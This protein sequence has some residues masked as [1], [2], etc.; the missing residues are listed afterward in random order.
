MIKGKVLTNSN[1]SADQ[2]RSGIG[3][4]NENSLHAEIIQSITQD[5]DQLEAEV[6]G[7]LIDIFRPGRLI[8]VQTKNIGSLSRK[9][10]ILAEHSPVEIV[11]PI[12]KTKII[13]KIDRDGS[14][15]G[16]RKSPKQG[17]LVDVFYELVRA[18]DII[19]HPDV[20]LTILLVE[21]K[22]IWK[23]DGLGSWRRKGWSIHGRQLIKILSKHTFYNPPDLLNLL[24][25]SL[26]QSFSNLQV[27]HSLGISKS[28]AGKITYTLRKMGLIEIAGH[29]GRSYIFKVP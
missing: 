26:P 14:Q 17:K 24:P 16:Q 25:K 10:K 7:F 15:M 3:T 21:A 19:D 29:E 27:A 18:P 22:E 13:T 28:A 20:S 5:G 12:Q 1:K 8:E 2:I 6:E 9:V 4:L 11:Y 23:N